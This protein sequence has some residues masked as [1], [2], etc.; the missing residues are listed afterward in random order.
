MRPTPP[1]VRRRALPV[2]TA[3]AA[4]LAF[5]IGAIFVGL[6]RSSDRTERPP[7][8]A[9]ADVAGRWVV[10]PGSAVS[11]QIGQRLAGVRS[12]AAGR[13]D[14]VTGSLSLRTQPGGLV[15]AKG[16]RV[17]VDMRTLTSDD[18]ARD[19]ALRTRGLE[20]SRYPTASFVTA[21][22]TTVPPAALRAPQPVILRGI[23]TLHGISRTLALPVSAGLVSGRIVV[24]GELE[25]MLGDWGIKPPHV[26]GL[27][28]VDAKATMRF[29]LLFGRS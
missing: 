19:R 10:V 13:T 28:T 25:V 18:P 11:Y 4:A 14:R 5:A 7:S 24:D 1:L 22:D 8:A 21:F 27:V 23:L 12:E 26:A 16:A 17:I 2:L 3:A 6:S 9:V 15:V 20:T 29:H